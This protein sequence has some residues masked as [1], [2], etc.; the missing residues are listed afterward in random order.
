MK[1]FYAE[2]RKDDWWDR[3]V[4]QF[5]DIEVINKIFSTF[6]ENIR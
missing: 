1:R 3:Q 5:W 4:F 2:A 6:E